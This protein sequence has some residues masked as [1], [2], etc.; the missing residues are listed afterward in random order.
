M[1]IKQNDVSYTLV[2]C[3]T[4]A[5]IAAVTVLACLRSVD[6]A[7]PVFLSI[8]GTG[9]LAGGLQ[10]DREWL[11]GHWFRKMFAHENTAVQ[12][13]YVPWLFYLGILLLAAGTLW[14]GFSN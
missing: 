14:G 6:A 5:A 11:K 4:F 1:T 9:L 2:I 8:E 7:I 10:P 12:V 13:T 3:W